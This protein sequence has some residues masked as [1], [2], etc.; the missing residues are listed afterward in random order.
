MNAK[1]FAPLPHIAAL[2][3][4][5]VVGCGAST[6]DSPS[7]RPA[8]PPGEPLVTNRDDTP[9]VWEIRDA[10]IDE[11]LASLRTFVEANPADTSAALAWLRIG[12]IEEERD[13]HDVAE[14]AFLMV[15]CPEQAIGGV[16]DPSRLDVCRPRVSPVLVTHGWFLLSGVYGSRGEPAM[17]LAASEMG[18]RVAAPDDPSLVVYRR[19]HALHLR[20]VGRFADAIEALAA[21]AEEGHDGD[22]YEI[23]LIIVE[24]DW[25]DDLEDDPFKPIER[26]EVHRFL[27]SHPSLAGEVLWWVADRLIER[28]DTSD[29]IDALEELLRRAPSHPRAT[30]AR[31]RLARARRP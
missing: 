12:S 11:E 26:P 15:A 29:G 27:D 23:A 30:E 28:G 1:P 17:S 4:P 7:T 16:F 18:L 25:N 22:D 8:P 24:R 2:V 6:V 14:R 21:L 20:H 3:L 13:H 19:V 31:S 5:L 9:S 10:E